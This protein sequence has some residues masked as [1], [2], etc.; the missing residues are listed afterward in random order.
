MSKIACVLLLLLNSFPFN[1]SVFT[2]DPFLPACFC[3]SLLKGQEKK[4][5]IG[6]VSL[7]QRKTV[8]R[9]ICEMPHIY[10][11]LSWGRWSWGGIALLCLAYPPTP[12]PHPQ[13]HP[14]PFTPTAGFPLEEQ[15]KIFNNGNSFLFY[16]D[17]SYTFFDLKYP[18]STTKF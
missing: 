14:H 2:K 6:Q 4:A 9:H 15:L 8:W 18:K 13:M 1:P 17:T 11:L 12:L 10:S 7:F 3:K 5:I 16:Y